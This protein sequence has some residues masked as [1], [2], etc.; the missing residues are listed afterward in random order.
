MPWRVPATVGRRCL[1]VR[2]YHESSGG[3]CIS[4]TRKS[5]T[6]MQR[7]PP[8]PPTPPEQA[9]A[10]AAGGG[11]EG[12]MR[13]LVGPGGGDVRALVTGG[14]SPRARLGWLA[15]AAG[16]DVTVYDVASVAVG[17]TAILFHPALPS[18]FLSIETERRCQQNE[19]CLTDG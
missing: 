17:E 19:D 8:S 13:R 4:S 2:L 5:G 10:M 3:Y 14:R 1:R 16:E 15:C 6:A 11:W 18:V 7:V 12:G 9:V